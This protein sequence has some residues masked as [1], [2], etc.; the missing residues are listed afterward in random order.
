MKKLIGLG[1]LAFCAVAGATVLETATNDQ[2][3]GELSK[4]LHGGGTPIVGAQAIYAC[5]S[6][7]LYI[8]LTNADGVTIEKNFSVAS[9]TTCTRQADTLNRFRNRISQT[10]VIAVCRGAYLYRQPIFASGTFGS[11]S[12]ISTDSDSAC[13]DQAELI[14]QS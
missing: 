7:Y 11:E 8:Y 14:N 3:L 1:Y 5:R 2:L 9:P 4:R 12:N 13:L 6:S 10:T